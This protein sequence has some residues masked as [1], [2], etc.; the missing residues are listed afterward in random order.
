MKTKTNPKKNQTFFKEVNDFN[1]IS[2]ISPPLT[3]LEETRKIAQAFHEKIRNKEKVLFYKSFDLIRVPYP[4]RYG[5]LNAAKVISPYLHILNRL[6][7]VQFLQE[8]ELKTLLFSPSDIE[9]NAETPFFKRLADSFGFAKEFGKKFM[10]PVIRS[11]EI[12]LSEIGLSPEK[13]DY[14]S[15][16]HLHTQDL[17]KWLGTK[18]R[19]AYFPNAKLLVMKEEWEAV[20]GL[21]P[22][23]ADWYC[24]NGINGIDLEKVII[25]ENSIQLG[26]G[27]YFLKT[28]GH[29]MGNHSLVV[30]TE[31]GVFVTSENGVGADNYSPMNSKITGVREYAKQTGCEVIM[32]GNTLEAGL[33]QYISMVMEKEVAG[34]SSKNPDFYNVA[35]SSEMTSYWAFPGIRPTFYF[36]E[37]SFGTLRA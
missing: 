4:V 11:V 9:G 32:N 23:Q 3:R 28:P 33:E 36:G 10:A 15:Y 29:T 34:K 1:S 24:P 26:D 25:L 31:E 19:A 13:V 6:F 37:M 27:V 20:Q 21:L 12:A 2:K 16:D 35:T 22:T 7:V 18:E 14:I 5:L 17:R 8:G 30:H